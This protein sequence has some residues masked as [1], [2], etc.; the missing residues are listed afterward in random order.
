MADAKIV[1]IK[2]VQ[3]EL[4]DGVARNEIT[5]LKNKLS[6]IIDTVFDG[7]ATFN[8]HMKYLG[9]NNNY[10]YYNFWWE[11]Q[12]V[13]IQA[14]VNGVAFYPYDKNNDKIIN[15]N[16]NILQS[17]NSNIIQKTQHAIGVN[18]CG[19]FTYLEGATDNLTWY[20]S[21]MGILRRTK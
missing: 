3:W 14:P 11:T 19:I 10:I 9:E 12:S 8:A 6:E 7:S 2:G 20:I 16:L 13:I 21:G 17:G 1:D 15:L 4:K 18:D 5:T